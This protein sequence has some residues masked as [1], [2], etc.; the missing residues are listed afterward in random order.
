MV[1]HIVIC[2]TSKKIEKKKERK[3]LQAN[4]VSIL[5]EETK[6][7]KI[8]LVPTPYAKSAVST[9]CTRTHTYT[10]SIYMTQA[11]E[12]AF[13][14]PSTAS[15]NVSTRSLRVRFSSRSLARRPHTAD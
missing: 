3:K 11:P 4:K 15:S 8:P 5:V 12:T 6:E 10:H 2:T 7:K 13:K 14:A 1:V 9:N